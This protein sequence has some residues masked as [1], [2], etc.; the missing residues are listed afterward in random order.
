MRKEVSTT[1]LRGKLGKLLDGVHR[2]GDRLIVNREKSFSVLDRIWEK[3]PAMS[4][5]EAQA[6]IE[7]AIAEGR[8]GI[9]LK[10]S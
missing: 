6:D 1:E 4:A 3:V 9:A 5:E 10:R 7:Q 8:S 2:D